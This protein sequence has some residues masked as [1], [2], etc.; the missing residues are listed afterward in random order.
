[1]TDTLSDLNRLFNIPKVTTGEHVTEQVRSWLASEY[2]I[3]E[4]DGWT[5]IKEWLI[6]FSHE[7]SPTED[8]FC[9]PRSDL[10]KAYAENARKIGDA[11][12]RIAHAMSYSESLIRSEG[13]LKSFGMGD[14]PLHFILATIEET[15]A[16]TGVGITPESIIY[17]AADF[18]V[19]GSAVGAILRGH[20]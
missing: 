15:E 17:T 19:L 2:P 4:G 12:R 16:A 10:A 11:Q 8:V 1:M 7:A 6:G 13:P 3:F 14:L 20:Q 5:T 9:A 18:A